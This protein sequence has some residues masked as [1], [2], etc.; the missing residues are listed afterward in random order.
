MRRELTFRTFGD[1]IKELQLLQSRGYKKLGNWD[2]AQVCDHLRYFI[3]GSLDGYQF[4]VP[5]LIRWLFGKYVLKR[6]LSAGK[7]P[8]GKFTPQKPLPAPGG[9]ETTAVAAL[10]K[11]LDRFVNHHGEYAVSPFF[12][13]MT[14]DECQQLALIHCAHHLGF[15]E[16]E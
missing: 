5:W 6:T 3:D 13:Q 4:Q 12:G 16:P 11:S 7:M 8:V 1:V 2:L 15:L 14:R 9:D 10:E